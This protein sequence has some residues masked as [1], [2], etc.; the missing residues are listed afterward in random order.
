MPRKPSLAISLM[1][2]AGNSPLRSRSAARG[3]SRSAAKLR[4]VSRISACSAVGIIAPSPRKLLAFEIEEPAGVGG[5]ELLDHATHAGDALPGPDRRTG[6][7]HVCAHPAG[8]QH[9]RNHL[10]MVVGKRVPG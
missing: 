6:T 3:R 4:A 8:M 2:S 1:A 5:R 9:H 7:A 10:A